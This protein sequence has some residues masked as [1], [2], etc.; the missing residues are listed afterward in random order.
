MRQA[1]EEREG[2]ARREADQRVREAADEKAAAERSAAHERARNAELRAQVEALL[3]ER[4]EERQLLDDTLAASSAAAAAPLPP[5]AAVAAPPAAPTREEDNSLCVVCMDGPKE[6]IAVPCGH[7]A[8]CER[9]S[10]RY[11]GGREA[12][13]LC[14]VKVKQVIRVFE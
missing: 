1:K 14:R 9:C 12:C 6:Y 7:K 2:A 11:V 10:R 13:P 3:R 8:L 5:P 4:E